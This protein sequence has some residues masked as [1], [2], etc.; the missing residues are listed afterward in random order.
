MKKRAKFSFKSAFLGAKFWWQSLC[1]LIC[2]IVG[3]GFVSGAEIYEFFARFGVYKY[4]G[5]AAVFI[6][7]FLLIFKII[8]NVIKTKNRKNYTN[9]SKNDLK[10]I[11]IS[12]NSIRNF[13]IFVCICMVSGAMISGLRVMA[14]GLLG[15]FGIYAVMIVILISGVLL[16][17]GLDSISKFDLIVIIFLFVLSIYFTFSCLSYPIQSTTNLGENGGIKFFFASGFFGA[18]YVF[19]NIIQ[20]EPILSESKIN[21]TKK[22]A[23]IFS[24]LFATIITLILFVFVE[25]ASNNM[26]LESF[27]MPF[28]I[29]F[30]SRGGAMLVVFGVGLFLALVSA[31][32]SALF[33]IKRYLTSLNRS[34]YKITNTGN[35]KLKIKFNLA[36]TFVAVVIS[37]L[38]GL[39]DFSVFISY[40]YPVIGIVNFV[41]ILFL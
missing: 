3:V 38:F 10:T 20:A 32:L 26:L 18:L 21:F 19:M 35:K 31:L 36:V 24:I 11:E 34:A 5:L 14:T 39:I 6:V 13:L 1:L 23:F 12:K 8:L 27:S 7:V 28:L 40:I 29:H 15:G 30:A 22:K 9:L 41:I 2:S 33:G 4:A 16:Y 17:F 25:F 37:I